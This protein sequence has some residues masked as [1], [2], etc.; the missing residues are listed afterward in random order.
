MEAVLL[1]KTTIPSL[2][3]IPE[4]QIS[5][6]EWVKALYKELVL[7]DEMRLGAVHNIQ[8]YQAWISSIFNEKAKPRDLQEGDIVLKEMMPNPR[9]NGKI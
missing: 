8:I 1:I 3:V 4:S 2:R 9:P 7:L 6:S 5:A